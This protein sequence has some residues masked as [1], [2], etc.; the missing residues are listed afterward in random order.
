MGI[1]A[2]KTFLAVLLLAVL[3]LGIATPVAVAQGSGPGTQGTVS[4]ADLENVVTRLRTAIERCPVLSEEDKQRLM[5]ELDELVQA[6]GSED[7]PKAIEALRS[8]CKKLA[9]QVSLRTREQVK[10]LLQQRVRT[11]EQEGF[12]NLTVAEKAKEVLRRLEEGPVGPREIDRVMKAVGIA[13]REVQKSAIATR[14]VIST[15]AEET[16]DEETR[17]L[18]LGGLSEYRPGRGLAALLAPVE[19][20]LRNAEKVLRGPLPPSVVGAPPGELVNALEKLKE[21]TTFTKSALLALTSGDLQGFHEA[22]YNAKTK[23]NESKAELSKL[24]TVG[25]EGRGG[26]AAIPGPLRG[27]YMMLSTATKLL[28]RVIASLQGLAEAVT[29]NALVMARG[30]VVEVDLENGQFKLFG[31]LHV[32]VTTGSNVT[33]A[34]NQRAPLHE[35]RAIGFVPLVGL[36]TVKLADNATVS[37]SLDFG[38]PALVIGRLFSEDGKLV[39]V[40]ESVY[41]GE[42][43]K[44]RDLEQGLLPL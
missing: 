19:A 43:I 21:S 36:W 24:A 11:L 10:L 37:G 28:E 25:R 39:I 23:L 32:V 30:V 18:L 13:H 12:L 26:P 9:E 22:L 20:L 1:G 38:A 27:A 33:G 6:I 15:L 5:A 17:S 41:L 44:L 14:G 35:L 7:L 31:S 3:G 4:V 8:F 42:P 2:G 29:G 16:E 40:A 34:V